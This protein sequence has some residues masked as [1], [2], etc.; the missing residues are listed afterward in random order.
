MLN[1]VGFDQNL[2]EKGATLALSGI[3]G[4]IPLIISGKISFKKGKKLN[5]K[6]I[7]LYNQNVISKKIIY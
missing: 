7:N 2:F 3:A 5:K 4:T 6:A 1:S